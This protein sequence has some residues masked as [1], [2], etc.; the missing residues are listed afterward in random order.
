MGYKVGSIGKLTVVVNVI[1]CICAGA[2]AYFFAQK[3]Y[4][5]AWVSLLITVILV[6]GVP[7]YIKRLINNMIELIHSYNQNWNAREVDL[8]G[9][10]DELIAL[11]KELIY[12][13]ERTKET[14]RTNA[15]SA[16]LIEKIIE[17]LPFAIMV[18]DNHKK[19]YYSNSVLKEILDDDFDYISA[20]NLRDRDL[21]DKIDSLLEGKQIVFSH[22]SQEQSGEYLISKN[23]FKL[24][25]N[26]Y[27]LVTMKDIKSEMDT[28]ESV[29][30]QKLIRVLNHEIANSLTPIA[31]L[32]DTLLTQLDEPVSDLDKT[33]NNSLKLFSKRS[34]ALMQFVKRYREL[35]IIET[36]D[37]IPSKLKLLITDTI[38]LF[39]NEFEEK[40]IKL[41]L[42]FNEGPAL[43]N[44]DQTMF[45]QVLINLI[46]NSIDAMQNS[47]RKL[48]FINLEETKAES[49][50]TIIDS[51]A[52]ITEDA[53]PN[54]FIPFFTTKKDGSGIGL[55]LTR[56]IVRLH[57]G[58][59]TATSGP[60]EETIFRIVLPN[61]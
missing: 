39:E 36:P 45:Q 58:D 11:N 61:L 21:I 35:A 2:S 23:S 32:S 17:H 3:D 1:M 55:A 47:I 34:K 53:L 28:H 13:R 49:I 6:S 54:I 59:I 42:N 52:G 38:S 22:N 14:C 60:G 44:I 46:K 31:S 4:F 18:Y 50:I 5:S 43:V 30:W 16:V 27:Y 56:Q 8:P 37:L 33:L 12:L 10:S 24:D 19:V 9:F 15:M 25:K 51:G 20:T 26:R 29:S 41:S 57:K 7:I 48:L 40:G